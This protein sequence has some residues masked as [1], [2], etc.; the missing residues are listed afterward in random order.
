MSQPQAVLLF[1]AGLG[2]RMRPL[3]DDR[4]KPLVEVAGRT[5]IDH[6]LDLVTPLA[7]PRVVANAHYRGEMLA[8]HLKG[9]GVAI[10]HEAPQVLETGGGLKQALPLLG[11]GP[12]FTLNTDAVWRGPNPLQALRDAW[13]AERMDAL[14]LC[15]PRAQVHGHKGK[16]DF[17][18]GTDGQLTRGPGAVYSG[19]QIIKTE[20]LARIDKQV[21]SMWDLW[22]PM[23]DAGR[24][25]G[26]AYGG[27]WCDVGHPQAIEIAEDM[28]AYV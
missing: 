14:L 3:T 21:F 24:M 15:V 27:D 18:I 11:P 4:P 20:A 28:L 22:Q 25:H 16:G 23:L 6:A 17:L 1:A 13:N 26:L 7:L 8:A 10:S 9:S 12:V 2:T 5:L 19:L